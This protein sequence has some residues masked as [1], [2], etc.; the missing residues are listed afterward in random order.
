MTMASTLTPSGIMA[1][2]EYTSTNSKLVSELGLQKHIEGGIVAGLE[3]AIRLT[4]VD[5]GI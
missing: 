2:Y 1:L 5:L 4:T 3:K